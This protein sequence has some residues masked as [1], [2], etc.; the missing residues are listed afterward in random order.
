MPNFI[1]D[2]LNLDNN[3]KFE[4][5][6][7]KLISDALDDQVGNLIEFIVTKD[8]FKTLERKMPNADFL[9]WSSIEKYHDGINKTYGQLIEFSSNKDE[10][11]LAILY[12]Q[13]TIPIIKQIAY[14][15]LL[16]VRDKI[17]LN[18]YKRNNRLSKSDDKKLKRW[19]YLIIEYQ[20]F[21]MMIIKAKEYGEEPFYNDK[22]NLASLAKHIIDYLTMNWGLDD[23]LRSIDLGSVLNAFFYGF[24]AY[25]GSMDGLGKEDEFNAELRNELMKHMFGDLLISIAEL[26]R[27]GSLSSDLLKQAYDYDQLRNGAGISALLYFNGQNTQ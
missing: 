14:H 12:E 20:A 10:Y 17:V 2:D 11:A 5:D 27:N 7:G 25:M 4:E 18:K 22:E 26:F 23:E 1:Y 24:V 8:M 21:K 6:F 13:S 15:E 19:F 9:E 16:H 3:K